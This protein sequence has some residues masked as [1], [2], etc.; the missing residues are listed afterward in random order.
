MYLLYLLY[1]FPFLS[2]CYFAIFGRMALD[3]YLAIGFC[4]FFVFLMQTGPEMRSDV[5]GFYSVVFILF[6]LGL[7]VYLI[8][9]VY[10]KCCMYYHLQNFFMAYLSNK[11]STTIFFSRCLYQIFLK[12]FVWIIWSV[13]VAYLWC[14]FI[15]FFLCWI[16]IIVTLTYYVCF[17]CLPNFVLI[18]E[19]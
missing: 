4:L 2:L 17:V 12:M 14:M 1:N 8:D 11:L 10:T 16:S 9:K 7:N 15:Q 13:V 3:V 5:G 18:T 6:T 19:L